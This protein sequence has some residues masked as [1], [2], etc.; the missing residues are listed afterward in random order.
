LLCAD[1]GGTSLLLLLLLLQSQRRDDVLRRLTIHL[2][3]HQ[4]NLTLSALN[5]AAHL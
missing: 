2:I 1:A 4:R 3:Q 5:L